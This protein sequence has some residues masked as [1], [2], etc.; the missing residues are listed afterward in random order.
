M[1]RQLIAASLL[2]TLGMFGVGAVPCGL[3]PSTAFAQSIMAQSSRP[4]GVPFAI[5]RVTGTSVL[6]P[7]EDRARHIAPGLSGRIEWSMRIDSAPGDVLYAEQALYQP[8]GANALAMVQIPVDGGVLQPPVINTRTRPTSLWLTIGRE[9][10]ELTSEQA[11]RVAVH[12]HMRRLI[13]TGA[14]FESEP[15]GGS[16]V[17]RTQ[18]SDG[19]GDVALTIDARRTSR[20]LRDTTVAGRRALIVRDSTA[21]T[22]RHSTL[23]PSRFHQAVATIRESVQGTIVGV[24][25]VDAQTHRTFLMHDTL[26]M[27]GTIESDDDMGASFSSPLFV[28]ST[29]ESMLHDEFWQAAMP[30]EQFD[31][32]RY[33]AQ[34]ASPLVESSVDSLLN[35]LYSAQSLGHRDSI[36]AVLVAI[37]ASDATRAETLWPELRARSLT[38]G[39]T[40][41]VI[42]LLVQ[43][44]R[45]GV[46]SI[47]TPD[48]ALMRPSLVDA[49]AA[50][51]HGVDREV[52]ALTLM[53]VLMQ[54]PPVLAAENERQICLPDAC[55]AMRAD[56]QSAQPGLQAVGLVAAMVTLPRVWADSI[57]SYASSN[58]FL[59]SR[60]LPFAM[61]ASSYGVASAKAPIPAPDASYE[62]WRHWLMGR[63]SSYVQALRADTT[64]PVQARSMLE[65]RAVDVSP[66]AVTAIRFAEAST[67]L[68]YTTA[69]RRHR[70][71]TRADSARALFDAVLVAMGDGM[72]TDSQLAD[73]LLGPDG[74]ERAVALS[75]L[76]ATRGYAPMPPASDSIATLL[77]MQLANM[78]F[79]DSAQTTSNSGRLPHRAMKV[80]QSAVS[81]P[82]YVL[83]HAYPDTVRAIAS[84][85][86]YTPVERDWQ[87]RPG[88]SGYL[89]E[90]G[91]I[92]HRGRL[93]QVD[94]THTTLFSRSAS[95]SGGFATGCTLLFV[96]GPDGW[97]VTDGRCW[98]T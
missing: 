16:G 74:A 73:I 88:D 55:A 72:K 57:V 47:S 68:D 76:S 42:S 28:R 33:D 56:A 17:R 61:S 15:E 82:R 53:D 64:R 46:L 66:Q 70:D 6:A 4:A 19:D 85:L 78:V 1:S 96:E 49:E 9:R 44:V 32:L 67:D 77:G 84:D 65:P 30:R 3:L 13:E 7:N 11:E 20:T 94:V 59:S 54:K 41:S 5:V 58:P 2:A 38:V 26:V 89:F 21:L 37:G 87:L 52:L 40:A 39:D 69:L 10:A 34:R 90:L 62:E 29:R 95:R 35:V 36:R 22:V 80:Q 8:A 18:Y 24:R 98:Q 60:A 81:R 75:Q 83:M 31:I 79:A 27:R 93:A 14:V 86:G 12:A 92:S 43:Q 48:Y 50:F 51:R 63:D 45:S 23:V 25:L 97:V 71:T 91:P